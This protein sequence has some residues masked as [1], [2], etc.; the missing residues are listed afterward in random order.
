MGVVTLRLVFLV[1]QA[2]GGLRDGEELVVVLVETETVAREAR[3]KQL[4]LVVGSLGDMDVILGKDVLQV[5]GDFLEV[6]VCLYLYHQVVVCIYELLAI[7]C[8]L[9]LNCLYVLYGYQV[10]WVWNGSVTVLL[11]V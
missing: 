6:L 1:H 11:F 5:V 2:Q 9:V 3:H 4:Q 10:G 7:S 8:H